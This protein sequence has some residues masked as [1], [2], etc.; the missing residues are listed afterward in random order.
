MCGLL[1]TSSTAAAIDQVY[2]TNTT[3][4]TDI[5]VG[6]INAETTRIDVGAWL[7]SEHAISIAIANRWAAG[8]PV[9]VIGDRVAIFESDAHTKTEFYWLAS[10]GVPIRLRYNPTWYPEI[11]HWKAVILVGQNKVSFGSANL[12]PTQ[13]A[14]VSPTN[15]DDESVMVT[16]DPVLVG[17]FKTK[18]DRMWNDTTNEPQSI[19]GPAP[20]LKNWNDACTVEG[21]RCDFLTVYLNPLPMIISTAR[22]EPDNPLPADMIWSQGQDFNNRLIQ[23]INAETIRVDLIEYR[24]TVPNVTQALLNKFSAG[25]PVRVIVDTYQYANRLWPEYW[26]THAYVDQL[27]AAGI[28]IRQRVHDGVTHM[29]TLITSAYASN[30]SSNYAAGWQR[31]HDYFVSAVTK[32][33]IYQ[34]FVTRFQQMWIDNVGFAPFSPQPPDTANLATPASGAVGLATTPTLVWNRAPFATSYDVYLGTSQS[35]MA[36]VGSVAAVLSNDPPTTYSWTPST[37]LASGTTYFWKIVSRTFATPVNPAMIATSAIWSFSTTGT[38]SAPGVPGN[39]S[40]VNAAS[41]VATTPILTWSAAGATSYDVKVGTANP[42]PL[43]SSGQTSASYATPALANST[44]Y[45]WQI[46]ARNAF[47]ST[48]GPVWSFTTAAATGPPPTEIVIYASDIPAAN[49]HGAW[50]SAAD[51]TAA[52]GIKL[53]TPDNGVAN[54]S[55][56]L[57]AP[58]DYV[59]VSF[60]AS[61]ATPYTFWMRLKALNNSKYNDSLWVQFSDAQV[62]GSSIYPMN[63]TSG[64]IVNLATDSTASSLNNWGWQNTAY[65]ISQPTTVTFAATGTHTLRI[66]TREDGAQLDQIVL[67]PVAYLTA[68]PGSVTNDTTIVPKPGG[69][70]PPGAPTSPSPADAAT[71]IGTSPTLSWSA[72]GATSYNVRFGTANP[73][74]QV[75]TGQAAATYAPGSLAASTTYF[76]QVVATNSAGS[77]SGPVWSFTTGAAAPGAPTA[78]TPADAATGVGTSPTL[79]W[80]AAG[81]TSYDVKFGTANPP[82]QVSTGQAAATYVP[83]T[84]ANSTTYFWQIVARNSGGSTPGPVWSFTTAAPT[85]TPPGTPGS[86]SPANVATNVAITP[87]LAWSSTG[88]TSYDVK[89]GTTNPPPQV[90]TGQASATYTPPTLANSATYFW[91]IVATNTAG[92]TTGPVWSFTTTAPPPANVV[93]YASDIPASALHGNWQAASDPTSPNATKILSVDN[94]LATT[95]APLAAPTDYVDVTFT[96]QAGINYTLWLRLKATANSKFNDSIWVQFSD[97]LFAGSPIYPMNST[98]GLLVNLATD[99]TATSLNGWGWANTAYWLSQVTTVTFA[100]TGTHTIRIQI[101]EDGVQFDQIVLN[102][103]TTAPPGGPTNDN[104]IVPK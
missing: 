54:A 15:Y 89:F 85:P 102:P 72:S 67:S 82:P 11:I 98:S 75:S 43:V 42:P 65:W 19:Y 44:T 2:F 66:Q 47:G 51:A 53:Q 12:A 41:G 40:P 87:T 48:A 4:V 58:V 104:T 31:D 59:D 93:I 56:P 46:V 96:A 10:Q 26:L 6:L 50:S 103:L 68:S 38:G 3:N 97:A 16:D 55:A 9:R 14:P 71:G 7:L 78:P 62:G 49:R 84:L 83:G 45:F 28:P 80:S 57:A 25:V 22:L 5:L 24:L 88:A 20:Y 74:P 100:T 95:S 99:S 34:A 1:A 79:S 69:S 30:A 60:T 13:L 23:E 32:P 27:Y 86:P 64:L 29:K 81:A 70:S 21:P 91:Q 33:L 76:W 8:V 63:S 90:S 36:V 39:P 101:R 94:G 73:P 17:A 77:T 52:A 92:S 61:S 37:P 35:G 18:F